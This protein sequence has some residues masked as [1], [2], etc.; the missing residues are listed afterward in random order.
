M[1]EWAASP[2]HPSCLPRYSWVHRLTGY[3]LHSSL[4]E[5]GGCEGTELIRRM[6]AYKS[7]CHQLS[8]REPS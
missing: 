6:L 5:G 1:S 2:Q 8:Q 3:F 7:A 4:K